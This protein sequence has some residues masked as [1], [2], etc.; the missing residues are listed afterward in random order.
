[1]ETGL[2]ALDMTSIGRQWCVVLSARNQLRL[3]PSK[4]QLFTRFH[5]KSFTLSNISSFHSIRFKNQKSQLLA[6]QPIMSDLRKFFSSTPS[7]SSSSSPSSSTS[8]TK[9]VKRKQPDQDDQLQRALELSK[10][11]AKLES[12]DE[13]Q[14]L[15][16]AI[17]Q[18]TQTSRN[19]SS[20]LP[21]LQSF[22]SDDT[23]EV[24]ESKTSSSLAP[25]FGNGAGSSSDFSTF[26]SRFLTDRA[27][28]V[29][30]KLEGS[31]DL[32]YLPGWIGKEGSRRLF[33]W[34]LS[35]LNWHRVSARVGC[36]V[37]ATS[38]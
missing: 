21:E 32:L 33:Q 37:F 17:R 1:M 15:A 26:D 12:M 8:Q 3:C 27:P 22:S 2:E 25:L 35:E 11:Q 29:I 34:M 36:F 13:E 7:T 5:S 14:Q 31:L 16:E 30:N 19:E 10:K 20:D 23:K 28:K 9:S 4:L 24:P 38:L 18:S 6:S